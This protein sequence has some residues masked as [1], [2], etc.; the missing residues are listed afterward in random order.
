MRGSLEESLGGL[1]FDT[2]FRS[3]CPHKPL[4]SLPKLA[5]DGCLLREEQ[6]WHP[7]HNMRRF[8]APRI[9]HFHFQE[10]SSP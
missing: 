6:N 3:S 8:G 7:A 5:R 4:A 2:G 1:V 10:S 9:A